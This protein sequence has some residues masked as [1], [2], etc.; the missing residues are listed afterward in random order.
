MILISISI[1]EISLFHLILTY[2][3]TM[4]PMCPLWTRF[5]LHNNLLCRSMRVCLAKPTFL[6]CNK[7]VCWPKVFTSSQTPQVLS[8][9]LFRRFWCTFSPTKKRA[10]FCEC[11]TNEASICA[12]LASVTIVCSISALFVQFV[13]Q[14][15]VSDKQFVTRAVF[16]SNCQTWGDSTNIRQILNKRNDK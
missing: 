2:A 4:Q 6:C 5:L 13:C 16:D 10:S 9:L 7:L 15:T 8:E 3:G 12:P 11:H 14:S 1:F